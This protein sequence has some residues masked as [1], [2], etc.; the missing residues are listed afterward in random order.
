MHSECIV[1]VERKWESRMFQD[2]MQQCSLRFKFEVQH[3]T[4][5]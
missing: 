5:V 1:N 4:K 3:V 2:C